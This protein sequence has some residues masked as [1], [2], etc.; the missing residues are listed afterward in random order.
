MG[1]K[2]T[3]GSLTGQYIAEAD[4]HPP[5]WTTRLLTARA[6]ACRARHDGL[7]SSSDSAGMAPAAASCWRIAESLARWRIA[8]ATA[9]RS[10]GWRLACMTRSR[11]GTTS[12]LR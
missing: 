1:C 3:L 6:A 7:C 10:C 5:L 9:A 2:S 8:T 11:A 4:G 12:R